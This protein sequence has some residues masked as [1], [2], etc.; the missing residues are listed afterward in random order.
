M[1]KKVS[2][3]PWYAL[4]YWDVP[5]QSMNP[6]INLIIARKNLDLQDKPYCHY[7]KMW[8]GFATF[9]THPQTP[10]PKKKKPNSPKKQQSKTKANQ[11]MALL[12]G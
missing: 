12:A 1:K 7:S 8:T 9:A 6:F 11:Q 3:E 4:S 5:C 2:V 10:P